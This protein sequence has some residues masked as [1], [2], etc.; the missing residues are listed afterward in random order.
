MW[1]CLFFLG[2]SSHL[3]CYSFSIKADNSLGQEG[4]RESPERD[5]PPPSPSFPQA[6]RTVCYSSWKG[7]EDGE[8]AIE[9]S[10][11]VLLAQK[12]DL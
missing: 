1:G 3:V 2:I 8:E 9:L 10:F 7:D 12:M 6:N 11:S 5:S 4:R